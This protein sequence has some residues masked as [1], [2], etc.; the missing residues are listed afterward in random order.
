MSPAP[1][2]KMV[3]PC[4]EPRRSVAICT[5]ACD[6]DV[7]PRAMP[8]SA[9]TR[10]IPRSHHLADIALDWLRRDP[11]SS[12]LVL[13]GLLLGRT[14]PPKAERRKIDAEALVVGHPSDPIHP[15]SDSDE[16]VEEMGNARLIDAN[17]IVEWRFRPERLDRELAAFLAELDP[18]PET[19]GGAAAVAR[20]QS[21]EPEVR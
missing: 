13:Q 7:V 15:F 16:L 11:D 10:R 5:A 8:V 17:S 18:H 12:A 19:S 14:C 6:T 4:S 1:S 20:V 2:T 3:R 9:L 21:G